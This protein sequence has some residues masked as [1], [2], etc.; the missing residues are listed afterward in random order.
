MKE[1]VLNFLKN[2]NPKLTVL[3]TSS[4][5]GKT[6]SALIGFAIYDDLKIIVSTRKS[7]RK[8]KNLEENPQVSLVVG[9]SFTE[10]NAQI[11]GTARII[12]D[13]N[14]HTKVESFFLT[15]NPAAKAYFS[16]E[17]IFIEISP[18]WIRFINQT[19]KPSVTTEENL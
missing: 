4:P 15:Q 17:T 16:S 6:E 19:A 10:N 13:E 14:E 3:A 18:N 2:R 8:Y 11:D 7:T 12:T 9:W 5:S 1:E